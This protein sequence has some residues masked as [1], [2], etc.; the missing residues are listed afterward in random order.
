MRGKAGGAVVNLGVL[1]N[2]CDSWNRE[3][4]ALF[5]FGSM[6]HVNDGVRFEV[7]GTEGGIEDAPLG[8]PGI[9]SVLS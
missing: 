6:G 2:G 4:T 8:T 7:G 5:V 9:G 3:P 1:A